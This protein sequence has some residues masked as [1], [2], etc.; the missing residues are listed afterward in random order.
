MMKSF[1]FAAELHRADNEISLKVSP[2]SHPCMAWGVVRLETALTRAGY[3]LTAGARTIEN[4]AVN[5][6]ESL[7][8]AKA[9]NGK[10][11]GD[12]IAQRNPLADEAVLCQEES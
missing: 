5:P 12:W 6:S 7:L 11:T 2:A 10:T 3:Q 1:A 8:A 4:V 9:R